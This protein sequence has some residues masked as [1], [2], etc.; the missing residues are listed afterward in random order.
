MRFCGTLF[1]PNSRFGT[2]VERHFDVP[3]TEAGVRSVFTVPA[4]ADKF[5][6]PLWGYARYAEGANRGTAGLDA[7][8][9]VA[10]DKDCGDLGDLEDTLKHLDALGLAYIVYTSWSHHNADKTPNDLPQNRG[11]FDC[12]RVVM[13]YDREV[14]PGEHR[15]AAVG[16]FGHEIPNDP[17]KYHEEVRGIFVKLKSGR[18]RAARPRGWDPCVTRPAQAY[19]VPVARRDDA[20]SDP[21][22]IVKAGRPLV[23]DDILKRPTTPPVTWR[24]PRPF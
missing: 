22:V 9:G 16:I 17:V 11:P 12:F 21:T 7:I 13:P 2:R 14:S 24:A 5:D 18:E 23:V 20:P 10:L 1:D 3:W 8:Y 4:L 19:F 15:S 6:Q